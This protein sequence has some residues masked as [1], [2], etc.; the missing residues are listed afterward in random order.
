M[1]AGDEG[2]ADFERA[3][4]NAPGVQLRDNLHDSEPM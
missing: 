2:A 4:F 1:S 3:A